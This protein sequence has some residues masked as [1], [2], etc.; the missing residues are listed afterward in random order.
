VIAVVG[1]L[2]DEQID[3]VAAQDERVTVLRAIEK[4]R[5]KRSEAANGEQEN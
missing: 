1:D 2:S 3:A 5:A 4:E